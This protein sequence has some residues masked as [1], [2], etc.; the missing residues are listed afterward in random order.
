MAIMVTGGKGFI[1]RRLV[2]KLE[3]TG[4][5]VVVVDKENGGVLNKDYL[6]AKI[7]NDMG[8]ERVTVIFHL[9]A[10]SGSVY[11][12]EDSV[13]AVNVNCAGTTN[14]LEMALKHKIRKVVF[15]GTMSAYGFTP[16]PHK[17]DGPV[18]CPNA[19]V[20]TKLF[21]ERLM[22]LYWENHG[23]Q[24]VCLRFSSVYGPGEETKGRVA[25]PVTQFMWA[26][27]RGDK[28]II[29]DEGE[30]TRDLVFVD[31]VVSALMTVM[32]HGWPGETY[33]VSTGIET[34]M[35]AVMDCIKEVSGKDKIDVDYKSWKPYDQQK[36]FIDRQCGSFQ[37]LREHTG[38]KPLV[39]V[40]AGISHTFNYYGTEH[41]E[42]VPSKDL[43]DK[44]II[45][46]FKD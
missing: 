13:H 46:A 19:Y 28:P 1:G 44:I 8:R 9:G 21:G 14:L 31:D 5:E 42:K 45:N 26:V 10:V 12:S 38:W 41:P 4:N 6:E 35:N 23:L 37:K 3:R 2:D 16:I 29:F 43:M 15:A 30:Q 24:T 18:S 39:D 11:F 27:L 7:N 20:A 40:K 17:E 22:R 32:F 36:D 34:S 25:N 33:N